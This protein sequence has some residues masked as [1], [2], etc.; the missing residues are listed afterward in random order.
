M[1]LFLI[2]LVLA[3]V[4]IAAYAN[5]NPTA[6]DVTVWQW[7]WSGVP[8]WIPVAL[9]A[10]VVA[11]IFL[12]WMAYAGAITG[13]RHGSLRRRIG[14]H[15]ATI[16][17]LR[18]ENLRLREDNARL[19]SEMHGMDRGAAAAGTEPAYREETEETVVDRTRTAEP[20]SPRPTFGE[21]VRAFFGGRQR[22]GY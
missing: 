7:H 4:A 17:D 2:L 11:V 13:F 19:R 5:Q 1:V 14:A 6:H 8:D 9:A 10:G 16:G 21:R 15:E 20:F 22:A 18:K 12:V 3:G